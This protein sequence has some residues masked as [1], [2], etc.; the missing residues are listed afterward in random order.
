[1]LRPTNPKQTQGI[2]KYDKKVYVSIKLMI[3]AGIVSSII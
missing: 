1:M 3:R 2:V